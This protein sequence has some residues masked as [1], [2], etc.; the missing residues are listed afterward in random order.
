[1]QQITIVVHGKVQGVGYRYNTRI[2]ATKLDL[3]GYVRNCPDGTVKIV[4]EG[5]TADLQ[6]LLHWAEAG[7]PAAQVTH[8]DVAYAE[9][10][11]DFAAFTIER[12]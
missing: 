9:A 11:G 12:S 3:T 10:S 5:K 8:T 7:P 6:T 1:M 4:A 2:E